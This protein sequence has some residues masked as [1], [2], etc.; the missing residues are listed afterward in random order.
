MKTRLVKI[1][2]M[3]VRLVPMKK[4]LDSPLLDEQIRIMEALKEPKTK[5]DAFLKWAQK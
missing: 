2:G 4:P 5:M 1:G 3:K